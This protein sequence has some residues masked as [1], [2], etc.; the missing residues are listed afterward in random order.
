MPWYIF[1]PVIGV[2]FFNGQYYA[3]R[4]IGNYYIRKTQE[5]SKKGID[6]VKL[7]AF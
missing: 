5:L 1:L 7:H 3:Q 6:K 4:V 2:I